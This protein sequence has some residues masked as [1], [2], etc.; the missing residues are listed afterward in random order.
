MERLESTLS[1]PDLQFLGT[2]IVAL[3]EAPVE[4]KQD[5]NP[6]SMWARVKINLGQRLTTGKATAGGC[7]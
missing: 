4:A 2:A 3:C 7:R 5:G 1:G 6:F